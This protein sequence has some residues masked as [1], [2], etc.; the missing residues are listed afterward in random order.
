MK[1]LIGRSGTKVV[2]LVSSIFFVLPLLAMMRFAF[3]NMGVFDLTWSNVFEKWTFGIVTQPFH[4]QYFTES[5]YLSG[6]IAI[7]T[8]AL[9]LGMLI[10]TAIWV[11][12]RV[13]KARVLVEFL[14][15]LPYV[16]PAIALVAGIVVIKPHARWF[17]N[18]DLSLIPFYTVLALPFTY[19]AID[20][21]LRA[22]DLRTLVDASRN[23]GAGWIRTMTRVIIPNIRSAVVSATFL[24]VAVALG[25]FTIAN[26]LLKPTFPPFINEYR[27]REPRAGYAL[28]VLSLLFTVL[29]FVFLS[30][31][32]RSPSTKSRQNSTKSR[33]MP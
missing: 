18:S 14:T 16:I 32:L 26:V 12:L 6:K 4:D 7:G 28:A 33:E 10:P 20:S 25:E 1:R 3:Q 31:A 15:V 5:L 19:R 22:L 2:I 23:L 13:P 11:H 21:G 30:V 17:L 9:T 27:M 24:T 8:A 29:V